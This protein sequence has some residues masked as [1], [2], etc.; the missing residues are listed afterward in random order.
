MV[1]NA[2][3]LIDRKEGFKAGFFAYAYIRVAS[4]CLMHKSD[5]FLNV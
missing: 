3:H 5:L 1:R 2:M 4:K